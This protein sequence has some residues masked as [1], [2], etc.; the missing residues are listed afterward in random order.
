MGF[1]VDKYNKLIDSLKPVGIKFSS[2]YMLQFRV[3]SFINFIVLIMI[4]IAVYTFLHFAIGIYEVGLLMM[5][6]FMAMYFCLNYFRKT[7]DL[8]F[9]VNLAFFIGWIVVGISAY[10]NGLYNSQAI[11]WYI[12]IA[13]TS[14]QMTSIKNSLVWTAIIVLTYIGLYILN[15]IDYPTVDLYGEYLIK[16]FRY[17]NFIYI[18]LVGVLVV[19]FY[20]KQRERMVEIVEL[21]NKDLERKDIK[22][23]QQLEN[24]KNLLRV[25]SHDMGTP[26]QSMQFGLNRIKKLSVEDQKKYIQTMESALNAM[27]D[28]IHHAQALNEV[29]DNNFNIQLNSVSLCDVVSQEIDILSHRLLEK[30]IKLIVDVSDELKDCLVI[31]ERV[32]LQNEVIGNILTNAIKFS[33]PDSQ[34]FIKVTKENSRILLSIRDQGVG[35]PQSMIDSILIAAK[36]SSRP[37]TFGEKGS[38]YGMVLMKRY[39]DSYKAELKINSQVKT[40][41]NSESGTEFLISFCY[42]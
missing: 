16:H 22:L 8:F 20:T 14:I 21:K 39:L 3:R 33:E 28:I 11:A 32:S 25:I 10:Y 36:Q 42:K 2:D 1:I 13:F 5:V 4:V 17:Q 12:V 41:E 19:Y 26:L 34:I 38:G 35:M 9:S 6:V 31:A 30:N 27:S 7:G 40:N 29:F 23:N 37:G 15:L 24:N 18:M